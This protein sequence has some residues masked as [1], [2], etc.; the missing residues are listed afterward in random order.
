VASFR[1]SYLHDDNLVT[2]AVREAWWSPA[3][4]RALVRWA[5]FAA[6]AATFLVGAESLPGSTPSGVMRAIMLAPAAL[7]A[8]GL[9]GIALAVLLLPAW[10]RRRMRRLPHRMVEV[11]IDDDGIDFATAN[12]RYRAVWA[13]VASIDALASFWRFRLR[14]GAQLVLPIAAAGPALSA[15]LAQ[16]ATSNGSR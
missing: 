8:L 11:V 15:F 13:E 3:R 1:V 12:E 7:L 5:L 10:L 14:N 2:R 6:G 4:R 16:R 9:L